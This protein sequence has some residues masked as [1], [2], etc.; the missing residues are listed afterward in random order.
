MPP[1]FTATTKERISQKKTFLKNLNSTSSSQSKS[2]L[3]P[4]SPK[5]AVKH[6]KNNKNF[7]SYLETSPVYY[8]RLNSIFY[9]SISRQK[10]KHNEQ[11]FHFKQQKKR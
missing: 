5:I 4:F 8:H 6:T 9:Y 10:N 2:T 1:K 3:S 7:F 11:N